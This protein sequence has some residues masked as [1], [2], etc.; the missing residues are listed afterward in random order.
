MNGFD[1]SKKPVLCPAC[2]IPC[3]GREIAHVT[4]Y[5]CPKCEAVY[6]LMDGEPVPAKEH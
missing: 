4:R 3:E 2:K 1:E 6:A 5:V